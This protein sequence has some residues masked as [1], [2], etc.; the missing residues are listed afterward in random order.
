M[1]I[2]PV[3]R[4]LDAASSLRASRSWWDASA[5]EYQVEHGDFLG[6]SDFLWCP[7]GLRESE[8]GL[9]GDVRG[10]RVLEIGAGAAQCSRWL[11]AAGA[12]S[13]GLDVSASQ[14]SHARMLDAAAGVRTPLT[15]ADAQVLPFRDEVFDLACSAYGAVPFVADS[16]AVMAEVARVLRPGGRWVFSLT[17]PIRWSFLDDPGPEGLTARTSYFDRRPYV[18]VDEHGTPTYVEHHRTMGD[19]IREIVDAGLVLDGLVEPEWPKEHERIWGQ[20]SKLRGELIPGTAIFLTH[21]P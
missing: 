12:W 17:H 16:A 9:L 6:D 1:I 3:R 4:K 10:K 11:A 5:A 20:W 7:E 21:K 19:R 14:L 15:L 2:K 8:A 18:E 13:V